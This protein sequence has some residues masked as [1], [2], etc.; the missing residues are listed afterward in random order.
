MANSL[1]NESL[2]AYP[3]ILCQPL[4]LDNGCSGRCAKHNHNQ[5]I[6]KQTNEQKQYHTSAAARSLHPWQIPISTPSESSLRG[7]GRLLPTE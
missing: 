6:S 1:V 3:L 7:P 4:R 5:S 2:G